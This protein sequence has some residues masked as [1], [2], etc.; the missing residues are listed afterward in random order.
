MDYSA[1]AFWLEFAIGGASLP[2]FFLTWASGYMGMLWERAYKNR[3]GLSVLNESK[4]PRR[5]SKHA[6]DM[7]AEFN[8]A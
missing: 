1:G 5:K 6:R 4:W 2:F 8:E 3:W 7:E